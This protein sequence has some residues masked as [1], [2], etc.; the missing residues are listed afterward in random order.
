M[1]DRDLEEAEEQYQ[2]ALRNHLIHTD[3]LIALQNSRLRG[4]H[5]EFERDLNI[6]KSEFDLEK[7]ELIRA[8]MQERKELEDMIDTI[9]EEE[10]NKQKELKNQFEDEREN[11]KNHNVEKLESMKHDLIKKIEELDKD[12]EVNFNRYVNETESKSKE[13]KT[14]LTKNEDDSEKINKS[15]RKINRLKNNISYWSLKIDQHK[16][17]CEDRNQKLKKEK[18]SISK[19]SRELKKK[20]ISFRDDEER[21]LVNLTMNAKNCMDKLYSYQKLA[22]KILKTAELCRKL[23]T[24]KEKVL[25]FYQADPET[26][27]DQPEHHIEKV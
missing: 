18:D 7:S 11:T 8:H 13:Y 9:V 16:N 19:H 4:L 14:M 22:E 12:F 3:D 26:I 21:R 25:P 5:E 2:M 15:M 6:L 24:E 10:T 27:A 1:L 23:E 17:E 20:M